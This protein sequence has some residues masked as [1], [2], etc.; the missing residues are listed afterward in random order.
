MTGCCSS[1]GAGGSEA[2]LDTLIQ[3]RLRAVGRDANDKSDKYRKIKQMLSVRAP[4]TVL[5]LSLSLSPLS[6][7]Q[8]HTA[9][10]H[11]SLAL[12]SRGSW[13]FASGGEWTDFPQWA[14]GHRPLVLRSYQHKPVGLSKTNF[15]LTFEQKENM[16]H[17][18][19]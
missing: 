17:N 14:S 18:D 12:F 13:I 19:W 3:S 2:M 16:E 11:G 10:R 1:A 5:S 15:L 4:Q 6:W 8:L 7:M 9:H